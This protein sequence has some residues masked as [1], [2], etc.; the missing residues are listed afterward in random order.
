MTY[1]SVLEALGDGTRRRLVELLR[2]RPCTVSELTEAVP[3]SQPAVSQHLKVLREAG[4]VTA[5][6]D[7]AR[8]I[9]R[10]RTE[11]WEPLR[12]WVESFWDEALEAFRS[13]FETPEE[14]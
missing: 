4:L 14:G 13:S 9:Y 3:V 12:V 2:S 5:E 1:D 6:K 8:R 10:V 7:G 11:G